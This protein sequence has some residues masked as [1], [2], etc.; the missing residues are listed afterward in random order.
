MAN[1]FSQ[2][3][4]LIGRGKT[5]G[6]Y[7]TQE[8]AYDAMSMVLNNQTTPEQLGAFLMLLRVR[9]ESSE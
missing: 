7:L 6:K 1:N 3:V 9:E 8:Q 4:Q 5:A 2:Y